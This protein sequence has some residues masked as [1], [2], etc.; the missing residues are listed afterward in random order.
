MTR[1][2]NTARIDSFGSRRPRLDATK[3][4]VGL[5]Y[6]F[7]E[8][9]NLCNAWGTNLPLRRSAFV[10]QGCMGLSIMPYLADFRD[11][12]GDVFEPAFCLIGCFLLVAFWGLDRYVR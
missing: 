7:R 4:R 10:G 1:M 12:C 6:R 8:A 11:R 3:R 2:S 5:K 9:N